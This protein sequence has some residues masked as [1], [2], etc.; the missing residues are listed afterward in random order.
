MIITCGW[1]SDPADHC[2]YLVV[3]HTRKTFS[4]PTR[5]VLGILYD[6]KGGFS[7]CTVDSLCDQITK[8]G[9]FKVSEISTFHAISPRARPSVSEQRSS[10][11]A[12][13]IFGVQKVKGMGALATSFEDP[14]ET[15]VIGHSWGWHATGDAEF[16][17]YGSRFQFWSQ[18]H[19]PN[20][21]IACA[22]HIAF[23]ALNFLMRR[24]ISRAIIGRWLF[25]VGIGPS[26]KQR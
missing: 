1:G 13:D 7:S 14:I 9:A 22:Y 25:P 19:F 2:T 23:A 20:T 12:M 11:P 16:L 24:E 26:D 5:D 6:I 4:A 8:Y 15:P 10:L 17:D 18:I 21:T 3:S